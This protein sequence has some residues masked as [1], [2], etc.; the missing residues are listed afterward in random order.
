M[1]SSS[2]SQSPASSSVVPERGYVTASAA[3]ATSPAALVESTEKYENI[4]GIC[5]T[6][7]HPVDN[8]RGRLNSCG[9]LFCS[10]CIKEWAKNTNV[11]PNCKARFTR[12]YTFH[13]DSGK[14]EETK[15][16]KRNYVAW[17]TS[18]Y[19]EEGEDDAVNE[20]A[21]LNSVLCDVCKK[22]DNAARMI[23]CDRRQ[24]VYTAHLDCL[25]L[26]ERPITF[27]C[28]ACR[29]LREEEGDDHVPLAQTFSAA[30]F[31]AASPEPPVPPTPV[32][33]AA[34]PT[35]RRATARAAP[36][37]AVA[38]QTRATVA[39]VDTC[40]GGP[41]AEA[42]TSVSSRLA[43][44]STVTAAPRSRMPRMTNNSSVEC[45]SDRR[46]SSS[47]SSSAS[48]RT[49]SSTV[50]RVRIDFSKPHLPL[51]TPAT[52]TSQ[53]SSRHIPTPLHTE[54][55]SA[56][57]QEYYF[58]APVSHAV[59]AM[60]ELNRV[61]QAR[62]AAAQTRLQ[63]ERAKAERL[64]AAYDAHRSDLLPSGARKRAHRSVADEVIAELESAEEEFRD[65]QQ[66]RLM[67]ERMVRKWAADILPVL[68]RRRYIEGDTATAE[69]DL[70]AQAISQA[71]T[72]VRQK[73]GAKSESLRRRR[74]Q[75]VRAQAHREA[76]ALAKLA[77]IIAQHREGS[78]RAD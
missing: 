67:E 7:I 60:I 47:A 21:L 4:C 35:R 32:T 69:S 14:E 38:A 11:C 18:Y 17:E 61:K 57:D 29:K 59:A 30:S 64:Q 72:M 62:A 20:E 54:V 75:L 13:A 24:C 8:P 10:Y 70:W 26:A 41:S 52:T 25:G 1:S 48:M 15:V 33:V 27:L 37:P 6:D 36:T 71:R 40:G 45:P 12:I 28:A 76:A 78:L 44:T 39:A 9:H 49:E 74:E 63:R 42:P 65:P 23:F 58:L 55:A 50:P 16:R 53:P 66:R 68:R 3:P 19:D 51:M 31:A 73:L 46:S 2:P 22:S 34:A 77:R 43:S 5:L 56:A